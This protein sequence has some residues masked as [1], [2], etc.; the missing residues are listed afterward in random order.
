MTSSRAMSQAKR[1]KKDE[2]YTQFDV[3]E[4][5]MNN[6]KDYFKGKVIFCNCD[7]PKQS[8]F[9]QYFVFNFDDLGLK[10]LVS[11]HYQPS[12][13]FERRKAYKKI[14]DGKKDVETD[15]KGDGDFRSDECTKLL[16][17]ADIIITNP[18]F[19]LFREYVEHLMEHRK[20]FLIIGNM[21]A[22][23]YKE[24]FPLIQNNKM[25]MG[26]SIKSGDREFRVPNDY[27]L[28]AAG[29]R[30]DE[31][32]RKY[33]RVKG[34]RWFTNLKHN[35]RNVPLNLWKRYNKKEYPVYDNYNAIEI[36]KT[37]HI[38]LDWDGEMGVPIT[39][40]DK[41]SPKQFNIIGSDWQLKKTKKMEGNKT[42]RFYINGKR[43]YAR[44]IIK[45]KGK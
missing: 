40:L 12:V 19:S 2:F 22:T 32:G 7:D 38:P 13:L 30:T 3:V 25:W 35:D 29:H 26:C 39:F 43:L 4:A 36:N 33:I 45:R 17:E 10:K 6:Y 20:K 15:L 9:W 11:T 14:Y 5:E 37:K 23:T 31:E 44:I 21:N 1:N 27:P 42:D 8:Q 24:I 28:N 34:V 16:K 41:Y 18:P